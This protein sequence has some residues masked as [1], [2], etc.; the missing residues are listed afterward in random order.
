MTMQEGEKLSLNKGAD[1][2]IY[3]FSVELD[4]MGPPSLVPIPAG[5]MF[6]LGYSMDDVAD[7]LIKRFGATRLTVMHH[8][9]IAFKQML[10]KIEKL[11]EKAAP[12]EPRPEMRV[13]QFV[14][15]LRLVADRYV[16]PEDRSAL[17]GIIGRVNFQKIK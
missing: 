12:A 8:G 13:E 2:R 9:D 5:G 7:G 1:L 4:R 16:A 17:L 6:F 15:S 3:C 10:D 11:D 14:N